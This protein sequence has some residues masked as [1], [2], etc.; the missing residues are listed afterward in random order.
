MTRVA[1][2]PEF[3]PLDNTGGRPDWF[4]FLPMLRFL[5]ANRLD[6]DRWYGFVSP[7]F[8]EK[9]GL[10]WPRMQAL[11]VENPE[12]DVA[13]FSPLWTSLAVCKNPWDQGERAHPGLIAATEAFLRSRGDSTS[14]SGLVTDFDTCVNSNY[15]IARAPFWRA[16]QELAEAYL[17]YVEREGADGLPDNETTTYRANRDVALK[18]FVQERLVNLLLLEQRFR[19]VRPDYETEGPIVSFYDRRWS[20]W[21]YGRCDDA[22]RAAATGPGRMAWLTVFHGLRL[23]IAALQRLHNR[24][25]M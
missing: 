4:E 21:L 7:K 19:V 15:F 22:K 23:T 1:V 6:P 25:A 8:P 16:W 2:R 9:T 17:A 18:V 13:L 24:K 14:L 12:A 10:G 5:R 3:L 20:R 11:L